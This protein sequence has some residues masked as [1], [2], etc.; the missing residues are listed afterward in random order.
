LDRFQKKVLT[1]KWEGRSLGRPQKWTQWFWFK[2]SVTGLSK[3]NRRNYDHAYK[4]YGVNY[5]K[6]NNLSRKK[7]ESKGFLL[8]PQHGS[9]SVCRLAAALIYSTHNNWWVYCSLLEFSLAC[10]QRNIVYLGRVNCTASSLRMPVLQQIACCFLKVFQHSACVE[11]SLLCY[12][13]INGECWHLFY[14]LL[15]NTKTH[16][17]WNS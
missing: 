3:R 15:F 2:I 9:T 8:N 14:L 17:I 11:W 4:Q 13:D 12:V 16:S 6:F 1:Y 5:L 10:F 7:V